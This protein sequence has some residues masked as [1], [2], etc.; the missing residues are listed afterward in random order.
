MS[1]V[2]TQRASCGSEL[3]VGELNRSEGRAYQ[4]RFGKVRPGEVH[5]AEVHT[6]ELGPGEVRAVGELRAGECRA[7][8]VY[9]PDAARRIPAPDHGKAPDHG[10]GG[11]DVGL[12]RSPRLCAVRP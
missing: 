10:E 4:D 5:T 7:R 1:L 2:A 6:G 8:E 9:G 3:R 11:L 12:W